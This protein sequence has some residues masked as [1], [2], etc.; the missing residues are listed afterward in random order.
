MKMMNR[1]KKRKHKKKDNIKEKKDGEI[2]LCDI[3][4]EK[5]KK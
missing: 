1:E 4:N 5:Y 3:Y 2:F